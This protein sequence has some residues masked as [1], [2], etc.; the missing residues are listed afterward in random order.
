MRRFSITLD[1][2]NTCECCGGPLPEHENKVSAG[3]YRVDLFEG[4]VPTKVQLGDGFRV[5]LSRGKLVV[6]IRQQPSGQRAWDLASHYN[7]DAF[8]LKKHEK[9][10]DADWYWHAFTFELPEFK[11]WYST[12]FAELRFVEVQPFKLDARNCRPDAP[13]SGRLAV[14]LE[15]LE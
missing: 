7:P 4:D 12:W 13:N 10:D 14:K 8:K 2:P 3:K 5:T 9:V 1:L 11:P 6:E 15:T